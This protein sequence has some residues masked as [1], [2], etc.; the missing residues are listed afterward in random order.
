MLVFDIHSFLEQ[1][2]QVK[3][4]KLDETICHLGFYLFSAHPVNIFRPRSPSIINI[5]C[6]DRLLLLVASC[7]LKL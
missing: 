2:L 6:F 3:T 7:Q 1:I 5:R 4:V